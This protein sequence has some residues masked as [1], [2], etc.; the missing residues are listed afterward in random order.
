MVP[1][2][3]VT[4]ALVLQWVPWQSF[5]LPQRSWYLA[6]GGWSS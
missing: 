3:D 5:Q 6:Y 1:G 2:Q 4:F